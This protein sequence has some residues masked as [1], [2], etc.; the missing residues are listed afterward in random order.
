MNKNRKQLKKDLRIFDK[1]AF[2][3]LKEIGGDRTLDVK[4]VNDHGDGIFIL[5]QGYGEHCAADGEG[6][7]ICLEIVEGKLR[8]V[9][10]SDINREDHTD[11]INLEKAREDKRNFD[12]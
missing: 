12:F 7:P 2:F 10:W 1:E 3:N 5:P 9:V 4:I 8:L 6:A 11:I